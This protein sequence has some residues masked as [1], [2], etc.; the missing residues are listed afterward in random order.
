MG[1]SHQRSYKRH[2]CMYERTDSRGRPVIIPYVVYH[3][4]FS[5]DKDINSLSYDKLMPFILETTL[6]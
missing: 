2:K 5:F 3:Y 1:N 6:G 4:L